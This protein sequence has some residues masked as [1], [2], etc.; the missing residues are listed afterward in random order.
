MSGTGNES[1]GTPQALTGIER[2]RPAA[3]PRQR[4]KWQEETNQNTMAAVPATATTEIIN[5]SM[6]TTAIAV[7]S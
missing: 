2:A 4:R 3:C 5:L 7:S 1:V 6:V